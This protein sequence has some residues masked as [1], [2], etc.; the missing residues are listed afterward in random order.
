[1][2]R[3]TV[4]AAKAE[5]YG[6]ISGA[7][8]PA[9]VAAAY[10]HEPLPGHV[11][12]PVAITISTAGWDGNFW[13]FALRVY[14]TAEIDAR[15]AQQNLDVVMADVESKLTSGFGRAAWSVDYVADLKALVATCILPVGREDW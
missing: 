12:K 11:A 6:L 8:L 5:L 15:T 14:Q 13:L 4:T 1:M 10:D 3:T 2:S 7:N 9:G